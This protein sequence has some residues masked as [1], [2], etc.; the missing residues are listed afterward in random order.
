[1]TIG[2]TVTIAGNITADPELR[3]TQNGIPVASFNVAHTERRLNR[4]T[5]EWED[6]GDTLFLRVNVWRDHG[7]N[8][9]ASLHK[10]DA[11]ICIGRL[12]SRSWETDAGE[13]RNS[14]ELEAEIV[15]VDLRRARI[16]RAQRQR[17]LDGPVPDEPWA[18]P[19]SD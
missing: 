9:A 7:E 15:S 10:G 14:V 17:K 8:V 5:N 1:M 6:F 4:A 13:K 11:V 12:V 19:S 2:A 18:T 3:F 16:D